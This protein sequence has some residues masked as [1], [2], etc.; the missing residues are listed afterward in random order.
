VPNLHARDGAVPDVGAAEQ[1]SMRTLPRGGRGRDTVPRALFLTGTELVALVVAPCS[2]PDAERR[3][4]ERSV[5]MKG[6]LLLLL[7][8]A[9]LLAGWLPQENAVEEEVYRRSIPVCDRHRE[10]MQRGIVFL[11]AE[12]YNIPGDL[13][14]VSFLEYVGPNARVY[15]YGG[16]VSGAQCEY[17]CCFSC[18]RAVAPYAVTFLRHP[19]LQFRWMMEDTLLYASALSPAAYRHLQDSLNAHRM[20][21]LDSLGRADRRRT[22][23]HAFRRPLRRS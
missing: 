1:S 13:T 9:A 23:L 15:A 5:V 20:V 14:F 12:P 22:A 16:R 7:S 2:P 11:W 19:V 18:R 10:A 21:E 3:A 8:A 17:W 4:Q 6:I